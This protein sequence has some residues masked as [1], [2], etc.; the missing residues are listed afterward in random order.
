MTLPLI[1]VINT[2]SKKDK[3]W[4]IKI[5]RKNYKT[6]N[7]INSIFSYVIESSIQVSRY[8]DLLKR[9]IHPAG[10]EMFGNIS[11]QSLEDSQ[12]KSHDLKTV[13]H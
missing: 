5:F 1:H 9:L 12:V 13:I 6:K 10:M 2:I 4:L 3:K 7:S 11:P 8:K